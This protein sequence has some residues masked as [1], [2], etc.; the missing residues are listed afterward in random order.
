MGKSA[1]TPDRSPRLTAAER[2][3]GLLE[4]ARTVFTEYG[5]S[6]ARTKQ[7]AELAGTSEAI[8]YRHFASKAD[9]FETAILEPV[10]NMVAELIESSSTMP[11]LTRRG[12]RRAESYKV[13]ADVMR[14]MHEVA[15]L[16][17]T[18]LFSDRESGVRFYTLRLGP[19]LDQLN[20]GM[21]ESLAKWEHRP[22]RPEM[23]AWVQLGTYFWV[24]LQ[25][26]FGPDQVDTD[27]VSRELTD[28]FLRSL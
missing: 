17:G 18:A 20:K 10:E 11:N 13:N 23:V 19:L 2:R 22:I 15:P 7:I 1:P 16:L 26:H 5:F 9:L 12:S 25:D 4:A 14:R 3:V 24:A 6:G 28:M 21:A 8:L 27:E